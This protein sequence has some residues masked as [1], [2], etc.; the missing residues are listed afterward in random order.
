MYIDFYTIE[1]H[2]SHSAH[3]YVSLPTTWD[4]LVHVRTSV[5]ECGCHGNSV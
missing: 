5:P 3:H 2:V 1:L 4:I